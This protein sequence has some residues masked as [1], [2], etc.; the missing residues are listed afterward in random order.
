MLN[1]EGSPEGVVVEIENDYGLDGRGKCV[2]AWQST[3][4]VRFNM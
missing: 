2:L 1:V 3:A 4:S